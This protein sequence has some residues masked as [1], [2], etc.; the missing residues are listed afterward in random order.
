MKIICTILRG[1]LAG[2]PRADFTRNFPH[3]K[4]FI[5]R[6]YDWLGPAS[7][8]TE[9]QRLMMERMLLTVDYF[10]ETSD[11]I[12]CTSWLDETQLQKGE[13]N[14]K[15]LF[16]EGGQG[17]ELDAKISEK[18]DLPKIHPHWSPKFQENLQSLEA[19]GK[20]ELYKTCS[21]IASGIHTLSDCHHNTYRY[22]ES[23][24]HGIGTGKLGIPTRKAGAE[25]ERLGHL[26]FG[27]VLGLDK[28]LLGLPMQFLLLELGNI[29]MGFDPRNEIL[30]V[31][32][33][34]G[35]TRTPVKEWLAACLWHN[36]AYNPIGGN[37]GGLVRH[38]DL[39]D[40]ATKAGIS[41]RERMDRSLTKLI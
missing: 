32:A 28:W 33:Y 5:D 18:T 26:L 3:A 23:W 22:I 34:L 20:K 2:K 31:Y 29:D 10:T 6:T 36:L 27:Y 4:R 13:R 15:N 17:A 16:G 35:E 21:A 1:Y 30:R 14:V 24:I 19:S 38:Q 11:T 39:L 37:P 40:L 8:L 7:K 41:V 9:V 12:P 25:R